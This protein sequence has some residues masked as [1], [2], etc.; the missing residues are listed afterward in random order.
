MC[1]S[2]LSCCSAWPWPNLM[3]K[4]A[5]TIGSVYFQVHTCEA[6][7]A[8]PATAALYSALWFFLCSFIHLLDTKQP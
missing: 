2:S 1:A 7:S 6:M 3:H 4:E 8:V 5:R